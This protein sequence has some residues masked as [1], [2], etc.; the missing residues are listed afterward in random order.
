MALTSTS[1]YSETQ[2]YREKL[3]NSPG[4]RLLSGSPSHTGTAWPGSRMAGHQPP[5]TPPPL[6][7]LQTRPPQPDADPRLCARAVRER[8]RQHIVIGEDGYGPTP[9]P[10]QPQS[11]STSKSRLS[12]RRQAAE[13]AQSQL[14]PPVAVSSPIT[15]CGSHAL[16]AVSRN[17]CARCARAVPQHR[18]APSGDTTE[19]QTRM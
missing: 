8:K 6:Q 3:T 9:L 11:Q 12:G 13:D 4:F 17:L 19:E 5:T 2:V 14:R 16:D 15:C 10:L 1:Y 18:A 7:S